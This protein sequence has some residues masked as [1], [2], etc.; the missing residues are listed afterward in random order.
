[1]QL[2]KNIDNSR[3]FMAFLRLSLGCLLLCENDN[4][5][6]LEYPV[7]FTRPTHCLSRPP[8]A[9]SFVFGLI[10]I[11]ILDRSANTHRIAGGGGGRR[12]EKRQEKVGQHKKV[13]SEQAKRI[14]SMNIRRWMWIRVDS[15]WLYRGNFYSTKHQ[16][17][18]DKMLLLIIYR[19]HK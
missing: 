8:R 9:F 10:S 2:F 16:T 15:A 3:K 7:K 17:I 14:N 4:S 1:M 11:P 19:T 6:E 5:Q 18:E 13:E 12:W